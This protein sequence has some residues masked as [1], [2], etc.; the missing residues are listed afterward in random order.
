MFELL[1]T[2]LATGAPIPEGWARLV[3]M[4]LGIV[5]GGMG[6]GKS[7]LIHSLRQ[8][9]LVFTLLPNRRD[10][11][12]RLIVAPIQREDG[13]TPHKLNRLERLPY[14]Q[15]FHHHQPA[16]LGYA[17]SLL[18]IDPAQV[19]PQGQPLLL[20]DG[21]RGVDEVQYAYQH[22][23]RAFFVGLYASEFVRLNRL[24]ERHDAYDYIS[25]GST[26]LA[27][28]EEMVSL[29]ELGIPLGDAVF[30]AEEAQMLL[31]SVQHGLIDAVELRDRLTLLCAERELYDLTATFS[32]MQTLASERSLT[33]DTTLLTP[34]QVCD[35]SAKFIARQTWKPLA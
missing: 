25:K 8:S 35:A 22:M 17:I 1:E 26:P 16:G 28:G 19:L 10:L 31:E 29:K 18:S 23:P 11:T 24:L 15:R 5:V 21:L 27:S 33:I 9:G 6:A 4:P 14:I 20:F 2:Y 7:T 34:E 13:L 30:T 32:L 3:D 12:E